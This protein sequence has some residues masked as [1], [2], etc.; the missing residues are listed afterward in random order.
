M[1]LHQ[2]CAMYSSKPERAWREQ[3]TPPQ[4]WK[5]RRQTPPSEWL[6]TTTP[7]PR[8]ATSAEVEQAIENSR[9][10]LGLGD[11]WN[12]DGARAIQR[13]TWLVATN[14]VRRT[15]LT[16]GARTGIQ[17]PPPEIGPCADGS[18][19]LFWDTAAFTLL[20]NIQPNSAESD[21]YGDN[22]VGLKLKGTFNPESQEL[23]FLD[24]LIRM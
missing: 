24:S 14:L 1:Q 4:R 9:Y 3:V 18:I 2:S 8:I 16:L 21:F 7:R 17:L 6:G 11:D 13:S 10:L 5:E 15:A 12:G 23:G 20:I 22:R 19:D